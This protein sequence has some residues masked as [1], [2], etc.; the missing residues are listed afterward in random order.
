M[1]LW[2]TITNGRERH[3]IITAAQKPGRARA[4]ALPFQQTITVPVRHPAPPAAPR[5]TPDDPHSAS[6]SRSRSGGTPFGRGEAPRH[7]EIVDARAVDEALL[8][9]A[10]L[11]MLARRRRVEGARCVGD[12]DLMSFRGSRGGDAPPSRNA[13]PTLDAALAER[14][15]KTLPPRE[16][17]VR[18]VSAPRPS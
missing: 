10:A 12:D 8:S 1:E 3:A 5:P 11:L 15:G 14:L 13:F 17:E 16:R 9:A 6:R 2:V 4:R 7:Q 18:R